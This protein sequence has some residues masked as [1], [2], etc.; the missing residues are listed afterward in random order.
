MTLYEIDHEILAQID[1]ETGEILDEGA[2]H[3]LQMERDKK[4]ENIALLI[5]NLRADA[6]AYEAEEKAFAARKKA[7]KNLA[8][9]LKNMLAQSL[10]GQSVKAERFQIGWRTSKSVSIV[11]EDLLPKKF[12]VNNPTVNKVA[13]GEALKAGKEVPGAVLE[14]KNNLQL[15]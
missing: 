13:I 3:D 2:L 15:K 6:A 14:T 8:E 11:N 5:K 12:I 4:I 1:M 9:R 7:A 10:N